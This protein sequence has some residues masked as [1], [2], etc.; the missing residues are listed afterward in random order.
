MM[1]TCD[2]LEGMD[3]TDDRGPYCLEGWPIA[4]HEV[5]NDDPWVCDD[6]WHRG[7]YAVMTLRGTNIREESRA[8]DG[9]GNLFDR[10]MRRV[11]EAGYV[12]HIMFMSKDGNGNPY[13][14]LHS[15]ETY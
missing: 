10:F 1:A 15:N 5:R 7:Q 2:S 4:D 6:C 14:S 3:R 9:I 12:G 11:K 13:H 8:D